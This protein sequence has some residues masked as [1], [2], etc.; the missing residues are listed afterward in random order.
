MA[1]LW[2]F[3]LAIVAV[4][5]AEEAPG[6]APG[7]GEPEPSTPKPRR[8]GVVTNVNLCKSRI[9]ETHGRELP[10]S[11]EVRCPKKQIHEVPDLTPCLL[12]S[13]KTFL[14]ERKDGAQPKYT[15]RVGFCLNRKCQPK[16]PSHKVPCTVPADRDERNE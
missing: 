16:H 15:C 10:A 9:L 3:A 4:A 12:F 2:I 14:L 11:C 7:C 1:F 6:P 13:N 8:Y 5:T